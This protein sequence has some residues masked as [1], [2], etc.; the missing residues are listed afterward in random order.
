MSFQERDRPLPVLRPDIEIFAGPMEKDGS[1]TYVIHDPVTGVFSKI[2]W[3][4]AVVL[5]RL[6]KGQTL[7]SM[8]RELRGRFPTTGI[9]P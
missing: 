8:L 1:P 9:I 6:R 3:G 7:S 5:N 4:E 2:G